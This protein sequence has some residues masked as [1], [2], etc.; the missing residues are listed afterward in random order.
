MTPRGVVNVLD[1]DIIAIVFEFQSD[2]NV[3]FRT[4]TSE[5]GMISLSHPEMG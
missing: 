5:K 4:N 1:C 2:Y 3:Y